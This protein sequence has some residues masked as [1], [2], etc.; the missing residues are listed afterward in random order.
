MVDHSDS[1]QVW[2]ADGKQ[3][4]PPWVVQVGLVAARLVDSALLFVVGERRL[5]VL[6]VGVADAAVPVV[7]ACF[8][9]PLWPLAPVV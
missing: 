2:L 1:L 3:K 4:S 6:A 8:L 7:T 5:F 9:S